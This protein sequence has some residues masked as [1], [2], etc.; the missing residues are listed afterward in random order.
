VEEL[1]ARLQPVGQDAWLKH[2]QPNHL[3]RLAPIQTTPHVKRG[4]YRGGSAGRQADLAH[5]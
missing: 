4:K 3:I 2:A 5:L 1:G